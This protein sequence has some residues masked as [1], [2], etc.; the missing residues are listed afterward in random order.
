[1]IP[2]VS[3]IV[4][5]R[6]SGGTSSAVAQE[7]RSMAD[8][9]ELKLYAIETEM[10]KGRYV[11]PTIQSALDDT[12]TPIIWGE[13]VIRGQIIIFHNNVSLK[14]NVSLDIRINCDALL[15]VTHENFLNPYG[16]QAF[17]VGGSLRLLSK[18]SICATKWLAPISD[19]NR[20]TVLAWLNDASQ[21]DGW[22]LAPFNWMNICTY[23]FVEPNRNPS[24]RRGRHSR[25]GYEKFPPL[26]AMMKHFPQIAA[27]NIILGADNWIERPYE[28]P[29]HWE[30][31]R[32]G[33]MSVEKFL[34]SI[35]FFVYFTHP[36][37]Q[38]SFG[39][40][41]AE[42]IAAGKLVITDNR[43]AQAFGSAVVTSGGDDVD[44]IIANFISKPDEYV[45]FVINAQR[46][47]SEFSSAKFRD[48]VL[49]K[50]LALR[51]ICETLP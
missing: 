45:Q 31:H 1:M 39:R 9:V 7:I 16:E 27:S 2:R 40:V 41:I 34:A 24:D 21:V 20:T 10:F 3:L 38:E 35:D 17:D 12:C 22:Q 19:Y 4:D 50:A 46:K 44:E 23:D 49:A 33:S 13:S 37:W 25:P 8:I 11:N 26:S 43:T 14:R 36:G 28:C 51:G 29:K 15:V 30:L 5:P 42:A 18:S 6:F 32:F 48:D 47:L